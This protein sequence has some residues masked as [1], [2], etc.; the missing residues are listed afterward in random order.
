MQSFPAAVASLPKL[1]R[2][3]LLGSNV[4]G[5]LP[6]GPWLDNLRWF[7]APWA[8]LEAGIGTLAA[9]RHLEYLSSVTMPSFIAFNVGGPRAQRWAAFWDFAA[10]HPP[11]RCLGIDTAFHGVLNDDTDDT[12][13]TDDSDAE[14]VAQPSLALLDALLRLKHRRPGLQLRRTPQDGPGGFV[15]E[16]AMCKSILVG[17]G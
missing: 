1:Q 15:I 7:G 3:C 10:E 8:L 17:P 5:T 2:L 4:S 9:A 16:C 14:E 12:D 11:L 13:D 6:A